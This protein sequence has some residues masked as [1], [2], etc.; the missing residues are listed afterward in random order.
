[1]I[2]LDDFNQVDMRVGTILSASEN[3]KARIPAYKMKIDFGEELGVLNSSAQ[4]TDLYTPEELVGR[5]VV[6]VVNFPPVH[7]SQVTS[8]AR[9]LG[10][11]SSKGV[12]LLNLDEKVENG[13]RI[14]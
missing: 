8:Q 1:M 4:I 12:V 5:Q 9:V 3:K 10:A 13:S 14:F 11:E 6:A 2:S 7:I